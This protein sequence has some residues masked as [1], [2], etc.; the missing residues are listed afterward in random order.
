MIYQ[1]K[2]VFDAAIKIVFAIILAF[3]VLGLALGAIQLAFSIWELLPFQGITGHYF[4]IISDVL[5]LFILIELS[6]SLIDYFES[7]R[8]RLT[9]IVDAAIVFI[10]REI[11]IL[12]F[13]QEASVEYLYGISVLLFVLG[14]LRTASV[15]L[16]HRE[17]EMNCILEDADSKK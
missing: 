10:I 7:N 13:K 17:C 2:K 12:T 9:F 15:I 4:K 14:A 11:L 8:L 6:R 5:T 3:L 16:F 1:A